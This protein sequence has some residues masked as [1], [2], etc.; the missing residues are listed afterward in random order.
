MNCF[1]FRS[2]AVFCFACIIFCC[3]L[4]DTTLLPVRIIPVP[5]ATVTSK[6]DIIISSTPLSPRFCKF[7]KWTGPTE[8]VRLKLRSARNFIGIFGPLLLFCNRITSSIFCTTRISPTT[9]SQRFGANCNNVA[10]LL[11]VA[12]HSLRG[13]F[14]MLGTAGTRIST[15][16]PNTASS[17]RKGC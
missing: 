17:V 14:I 4:G 13:N 6:R 3:M 11:Q 8:H 15:T 10:S 9:K 5:Q 16:T 12:P 7:Q 2:V 1:C